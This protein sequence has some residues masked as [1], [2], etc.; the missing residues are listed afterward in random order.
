MTRKVL[1]VTP[2][3]PPAK[4][5]IQLLCHRVVSSF[6]EL[7]PIVVTVGH[8]GAAAFD[9]D[10]EFRVVRTPAI[11]SQRAL[12]MMALNA[13]TVRLALREKPDVV[14][15]THIIA[16]PAAAFL[17]KQLALPVAQYVYA[18][19]MGARPQLARFALT[20][21]DR[22]LAIS[23]Y[24]RDLA[25]A[26]GANPA[27]V[28][29][30]SPA[31]DL[32]ARPALPKRDRQ[33]PPTLLTISRLEDRYKGHDVVLRAMPLIRAKVPDI[34]WHVI[35]EGPLRSML[36]DR[37]QT[38]GLADTVRFLGAV[39]DEERDRELARADVFCMVSRLPA[40]GFA[41]EGFGIVY[42][43]A[44]AHGVPVVAGAVGG[45]VDAVDDGKS[46][47]LVDPEDHV[48]VAD[49]IVKLL[50]DDEL[51]ARLAVEGRAWAE[52]FSWQTAGDLVE[53]EL[54]ELANAR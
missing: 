13:E 47:L 24:A 50:S 4:G 39:S 2:D 15:S 45:A 46:G 49:A 22:V 10:Q 6:R 36:E 12:R 11:S 7:E 41:G 44:N 26:A 14:L 43:E 21:C 18:K 51:A 29:L 8:Q 37:A 3:F 27:R 40:G 9:R 52:R 32:P 25:L 28:S 20:R 34:R 16:S 31:V 19:E 54:L 38:A 17:R 35:G 33:G 53:A 5:G 1:V 48:A 42:L 30:I 23:G